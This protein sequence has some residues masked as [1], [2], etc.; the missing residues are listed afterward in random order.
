MIYTYIERNP[1]SE[2][3]FVLGFTEVYN[4]ES[5]EKECLLCYVKANTV[6]IVLKQLCLWCIF[7]FKIVLEIEGSKK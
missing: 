2:S 4:T 6:I 1:W 3:D 5:K 7:K